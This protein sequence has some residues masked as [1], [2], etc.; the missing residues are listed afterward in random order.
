LFFLHGAFNINNLTGMYK[1]MM[2]MAMKMIKAKLKESNDPKANE[3]A[4]M[5]E[6]GIDLVKEEE[7]DKVVEFLNA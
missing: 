3:M 4:D 6:K 2:G 1:M 5:F 7:L